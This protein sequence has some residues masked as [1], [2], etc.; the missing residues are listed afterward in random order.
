V[1]GWIVAGAIVAV[2]LVLLFAPVETE[3][4]LRPSA[5]LSFR[6]RW[7]GIPFRIRGFSR[8]RPEKRRERRRRGGRFSLRT[9]KAVLHVIRTE[10]VTTLAW[11]T[12]LRAIDAVELVRARLV[13]TVGLGDPAWT[14]WLS[15]LLAAVRPR[16]EAGQGRV[17][18]E[19]TPD[20]GGG[21][22]LADGDLLLRTR[23]FPWIVIGVR[24]LCAKAT[25][26]AHRAW[27][28][29]MRPEPEPED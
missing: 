22:F 2:L 25:W 14:G 9:G 12:A 8:A 16:F 11:R 4:R 20:F 27:R 3:L 23:P 17:N 26:R 21:R 19:L 5:G 28:E 29:V 13:L 7:L 24:V 18:L 6:V 10:G 15:G 1:T